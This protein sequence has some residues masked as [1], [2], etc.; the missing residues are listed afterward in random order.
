MEKMYLEKLKE[1]FGDLKFEHIV[2][3]ETK[4]DCIFI[5]IY[6]SFKKNSK[7]I[8]VYRAFKVGDNLEISC[9]LQYVICLEEDDSILEGIKNVIETYNRIKD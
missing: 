1:W 3:Q 9:D 7:N 6:D 5:V 2:M 4:Y 8:E